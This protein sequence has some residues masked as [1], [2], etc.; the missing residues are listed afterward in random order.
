MFFS[1]LANIDLKIS[2]PINIDCLTLELQNHPDQNFIRFLLAGLRYGFHTGI[3]TMPTT[4]HHGQNLRSARRHPDI[5]AQLLTEEIQNGF[6]IGPFQSAPFPV[7]RISP[8]GLVFGKYSGKPRLILDLS[9]PHDDVLVPSINALIDKDECSM[10]YSTIDQ[11]IHNVMLTGRNS[12]L[13]KCDITSAFKLLPIR[14]A[15]VPFYGCCWND[16]YFFYVRLPFGGRSSPRIFDCLSIALE[17]ILTNNYGIKYCQH[18][19]DD[20][21][22]I[23][24]SEEEGLRTMSILTMVFNKLGVPLSLSK[25]IGPV[26]SLVY[27]GVALDA[28]LFETRIPAD[29]IDCMLVSIKQLSSKKRCTKRELLQL[30][31][32]FNFATRVIIPGRSFMSFLFQLSCTVD[33]LHLHVRLG[34][35]A[36]LDLSM[37]EYFLTHWNGHFFFLDLSPISN[38]D[39]CLYTDAAGG[40]GYGGFFRS[41]WFSSTWTT[42]L[43]HISRHRR[44]S[45]LLELI[46]IVSAAVIWGHL[47]SRR[48]IVFYCDNEALVFILNKRRSSDS[49]IML[50]IRR[51]TLLSLFYNFHIIALHVPG[52]LNEIADALSRQQWS[53]FRCLAP[54]ADIS[55]CPV[56]P[57]S[58]LIYPS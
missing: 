35:E 56:P 1:C 12:F 44:G 3:R 49:T 14:P 25:T 13:C 53:R 33:A 24:S 17:W 40:V 58:S 46:P 31:G 5:V 19:L 50:F 9:W 4:V 36:R 6:V 11:A 2:T 48:R 8:L 7:Y 21:L 38:V 22:T 43:L 18:L 20:F 28:K 30:L 55:P 51:L 37:W 54:W 45:S 41:Q 32:H 26:T 10:T 23:D 16:A 27:L 34:R 52:S 57:I 39:L 29:K 15:L 42:D 47:W